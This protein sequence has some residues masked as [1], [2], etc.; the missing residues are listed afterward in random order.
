MGWSRSRSAAF[1]LLAVAGCQ[2]GDIERVNYELAVHRS[3]EPQGR[4][5]WIVDSQT[6]VARPVPRVVDEPQECLAWVEGAGIYVVE[7]RYSPKVWVHVDGVAPRTAFSSLWDEAEVSVQD[8][9]FVVNERLES[10][11]LPGSNPPPGEATLELLD[12]ISE[13]QTRL[14]GAGRFSEVS[15]GEGPSVL[16]LATSYRSIPPEYI[17]FEHLSEWRLYQP[18]REEPLRF[19]LEGDAL[20]SP[21]GRFIAWRREHAVTISNL[22]GAPLETVSGDTF[23]WGP[24]GSFA[25]RSDDGFRVA[26][27]DDRNS[28]TIASATATRLAWSA[29]PGR[30]LVEYPCDESAAT[31]RQEVFDGAEVMLRTDCEQQEFVRWADDARAFAVRETAPPEVEAARAFRVFSLDGPPS[32]WHEGVVCA[33]RPDGER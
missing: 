9:Q 18:E 5:I 1:F 19:E 21:D 10:G 12:P 2:A 24:E 26:S 6:G 31:F 14:G 11:Q 16:T 4:R 15:T 29:D 3:D 25:V 13:I 23:T 20:L 28:L 27:I 30:V 22:N 7:G 17:E 32:P 8:G 33:F